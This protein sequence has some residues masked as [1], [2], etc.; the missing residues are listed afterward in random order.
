MADRKAVEAARL[1]ERMPLPFEESLRLLVKDEDAEVAR[2]A[3]RAVA[4]ASRPAL[5]HC[6]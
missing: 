1:A 6:C 5:L 2:T 4:R 3:I